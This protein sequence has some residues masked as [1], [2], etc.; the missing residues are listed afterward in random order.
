MKAAGIFF[1]FLGIL[2][3]TAI[4]GGIVVLSLAWET[5]LHGVL[6][7]HPELWRPLAPLG[8]IMGSPLIFIMIYFAF[9][10]T[11][12]YLRGDFYKKDSN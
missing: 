12:S 11:R 8:L 3:I 10:L 6:H 1:R 5:A 7:T 2:T 9:S 4:I